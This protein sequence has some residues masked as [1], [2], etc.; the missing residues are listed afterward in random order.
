[1][2]FSVRGIDVV[3]IRYLLFLL[4]N[5]VIVARGL[6]SLRRMAKA[7]KLLPFVVVRHNSCILLIL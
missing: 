7:I 6:Y 2:G 5:D 4:H 3:M 1:V